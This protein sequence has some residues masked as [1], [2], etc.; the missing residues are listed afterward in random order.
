MIFMKNNI[1]KNTIIA[2]TLCTVLVVPSFA[3]EMT[4]RPISAEDIVVIPINYTYSHW[5]E[6]YIDQLSRNYAVESVFQNKDLNAAITVDDF[7][8]L[9]RLTIDKEYDVTPDS[10]AREVVVHE[11]TK[12]WAQKT[13]QD[14]DQIATIKMI[15]YPDTHDIDAKYNHSVTVA[16][17]HGIAKGRD[18]G[19]FDAKANITYGEA[20]TLI[21]NTEKAIANELKPNKQP[22]VAGRFET[23]A[24]YQ[25]E[26]NKV[27]FDFEL[28]S[29]YIESKELQFGSGQQFE[30]VITDEDDQ[31]V[32]RYSDDKFFTMALIFK[33]INPGESIKWKDEW[34]MTNKQGEKLTSG[35]YKAEVKVIVIEK[36]G[37]EKIEENQLTAVI[38][39][40][41]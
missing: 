30:V 15:I 21:T 16:Y 13:G 11:L 26:D 37:D 1:L 32:Y 29:H 24:D 2:G 12:I 33:N 7:Q 10:M 27:V 5:S 9:I 41:L 14:L 19:I 36:D 40:S 8:N 38:D 18:T 20:A 3:N 35:E 22:I 39:F 17:M 25:I 28:M 34:D 23:R 6:A 31:E 4:V